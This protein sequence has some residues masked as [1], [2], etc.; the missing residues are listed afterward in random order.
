MVERQNR[1]PA[2]RTRSSKSLLSFEERTGR[3]EPQE[4][5]SPRPWRMEGRG[6]SW[7]GQSGRERGRQS[8]VFRRIPPSDGQAASRRKTSQN[9]AHQDSQKLQAI[10]AARSSSQQEVLTLHSRRPRSRHPESGPLCS[11]LEHSQ[12]PTSCSKS[13]RM[14]AWQPPYRRSQECLLPVQ[15][16]GQTQRGPLLSTSQNSQRRHRRNT[17]GTDHR[18]TA[19]LLRPCRCPALE[20]ITSWII[21][22]QIGV[23]GVHYGPMHLQ[24]PW[25]EDRQ[26]SR[27]HSH[28]GRWL[29]HHWT[30][31]TSPENGREL[32]KTYQFGKYVELQK[33]EEEPA[34]NGRRIKQL[35]T[36]EF[37]IDMEKFIKERLHE[38]KPWERK[39]VRSQSQSDW[40]RDLSRSSRVRR[41]ELAQQRR[42]SGRSRTL[43]FDGLQLSSLTAEDILE[44]NQVV[45]SLK[46]SAEIQVRIQL[47][48]PCV[49]VPSP[50]RPLR[51]RWTD[52]RRA[53]ITP[54][55]TEFQRR[56][57]YCHTGLAKRQTAK[58]GQLH[59][60]GRDAELV[61][62]SRRP[63]L[64]HVAHE[65]VH[66]RQVQ[67]TQLERTRR[68][69]RD[70]DPRLR[71]HRWIPQGIFG[72]CGCQ[73]S[74]WSSLQG[75]S[76]GFREANRHRYPNHQ[77]RSVYMMNW[78]VKFGGL[79]ILPCW[80]MV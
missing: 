29:V 50:T 4:G 27:C 59:P 9:P 77:A 45:K 46:E 18:D 61:Q 25:R 22:G 60:G 19:R 21:P 20:E 31:W 43:K 47:C 37:Q 51:Y 14:K 55:E 63:R 57:A 58:G 67:H 56:P 64:G 16:V 68:K 17:W 44:L 3:G 24:T 62:G 73:I 79:N 11:H 8:S 40:G 75:D 53:Q 32:Q 69:G 12:L 54:C 2:A 49:W 66:R 34:F 76:W 30:S 13:E 15:T 65:R 71:T 23:P 48:E 78:R 7:M 1:V 28:R 33:E 70:D 41:L 35:A 38:V 26:A 36:G 74:L 39:K 72:S 6:R 10:R 52:H 80:Q 42:A 5:K